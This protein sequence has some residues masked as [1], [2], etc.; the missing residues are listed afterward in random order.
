LVV[1]TYNNDFG[2]GTSYYRHCHLN[3]RGMCG[4][5]AM[6]WH[7][8]GTSLSVSSL[9][10]YLWGS[11]KLNFLLVSNSIEVIPHRLSLYIL[12]NL[13]LLSP[14]SFSPF[15][16]TP[17]PVTSILDLLLKNGVSFHYFSHLRH[18]FDIFLYIEPLLQFSKRVKNSYA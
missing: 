9:S 17:V 1:L 6:W 15:P 10:F 11:S 18:H 14:E 2:R 8:T 3:Y 5:A 16:I 12:H 7:D 4:S 13:I